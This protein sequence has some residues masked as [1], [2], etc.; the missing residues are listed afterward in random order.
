VL[1]EVL[2]TIGGRL[3]NYNSDSAAGKVLLVAEI[4]IYRN[5]GI[6]SSFRQPQK[7]PRFASKTSPPLERYGIRGRDS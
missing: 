1:P 2:Q 3:Q 5:Q 6:K 4:C 7:V